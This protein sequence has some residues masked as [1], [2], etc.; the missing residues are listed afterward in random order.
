MG[1]LGSQLSRK[2]CKSSYS[3]FPGILA[4][5]GL[6]VSQGFCFQEKCPEARKMDFTKARGRLCQRKSLLGTTLCW[7]YREGNR[8]KEG[9][10]LVHSDTPLKQ[11]PGGTLVLQS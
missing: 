1:H 3:L 6:T 11:H 10:G 7:S 9:Q 4:F 8:P 5:Q 2:Y